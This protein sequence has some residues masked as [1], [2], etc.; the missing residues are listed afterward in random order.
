MMANLPFFAEEWFKQYETEESLKM[1][2]QDLEEGRT[3]SGVSKQGA[4]N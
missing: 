4:K 1:F 2:K 3:R